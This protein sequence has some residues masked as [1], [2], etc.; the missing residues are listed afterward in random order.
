MVEQQL[1]CWHTDRPA[2][3]LRR[4]LSKQ[5]HMDSTVTEVG[6]QRMD[7]TVM[8][9]EMQRMDLIGEGGRHMD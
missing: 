6:M 4:D 7:L 5:Q 2:K 8:G 1:R 3:S 9:T